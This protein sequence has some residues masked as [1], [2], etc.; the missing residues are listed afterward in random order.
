MGLS[1]PGYET[2]SR[3]FFDSEPQWI[4]SV[5]WT[6]LL[7]NGD[8]PIFARRCVDVGVARSV[9]GKNWYSPEW[10]LKFCKYK[11]SQHLA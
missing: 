7:R 11:P 3:R 5:S 6:P 9:A 8:S 2:A 1:P 10:H 4:C